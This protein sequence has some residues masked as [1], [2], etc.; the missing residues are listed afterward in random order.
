M[1]VVLKYLQYADACDGIYDGGWSLVRHSFNQWYESTDNLQ[2]TDI[3][4]V[5]DDDPLSL[6]SWSIQFDDIIRSYNNKSG[7][8]VMFSNGDCSE[9]LITIFD[10]INVTSNNSYWGYI[11]ESNTRSSPYYDKWRNRDPLTFPNDP[12]ILYTLSDQSS[13]LYTEGSNIN[14]LDRFFPTGSSQDLFL[15]VWIKTSNFSSPQY[16]SGKVPLSPLSW[17]LTIK[18]ELQNK[19]VFYIFSE[20][21]ITATRTETGVNLVLASGV[22]VDTLWPKWE[23]KGPHEALDWFVLNFDKFFVIYCYK[24]IFSYYKFKG[25]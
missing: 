14:Y 20:G 21:T 2:G 17:S 8:I 22:I 16:A 4:G 7:A 12:L 3:Y 25:Q 18:S 6:T 19:N 9:Y 23:L 15:N 11:I 1:F 13:M 24:F 10:S 5:F